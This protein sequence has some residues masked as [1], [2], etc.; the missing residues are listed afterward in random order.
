MRYA[1][2]FRISAQR[3]LKVETFPEGLQHS[4]GFSAMCV[5]SGQAS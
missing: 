1:R 2:H 5:A 4:G 3:I